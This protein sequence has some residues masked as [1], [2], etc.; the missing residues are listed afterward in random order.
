MG[1][2]P[3]EA[4]DGATET[5][6][7]S[8]SA[9]P[10]SAMF[11]PSGGF[12]QDG[13]RRPGADHR[14]EDGADADRP[15]RVDGAA[16]LGRPGGLHAQRRDDGGA[17]RGGPGDGELLGGAGRELVPAGEAFGE[18]GAGHRGDRREPG[19]PDELGRPPVDRAVG[20]RAVRGARCRTR[21]R[22]RA[23]RPRPARSPR[24]P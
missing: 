19:H 16:Q 4:S 1:S 21:T 3:V 10:V 23:G 2:G 5:S 12:E 15:H 9:P 7:S 6:A 13:E 11:Q 8:Q 22:C 17:Q 20:E 18:H 24:A 14:A